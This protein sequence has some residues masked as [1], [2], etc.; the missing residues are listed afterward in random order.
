MKAAQIPYLLIPFAVIMLACGALPMIP[1]DEPPGVGE[2]AE[3][4]YA[5]SEPVIAALEEYQA[6]KAAYPETL[7]ELVP[8]YLPA[9][10]TKTDELD[11]SYSKNG[12]SFSFSFHYRGPGLNTCTYT[13]EEKWNC[14]GAY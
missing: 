14:S 7:A 6:D 8:D 5:A 13:P 11:F 12:E 3:K 2:K 4:G 1:T 9:V 10:P